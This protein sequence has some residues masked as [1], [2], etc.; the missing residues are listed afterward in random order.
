MIRRTVEVSTPS[1]LHVQHAQLVIE[2]DGERAGQVPIEDLGVLLVDH[3]GAVL[4]EGL[5]AACAENDATVV[6]CDDKHLPSA[7]LLPLAGHSVQAETIRAQTAMSLPLRKRLW[8]QVVQ[9]K[10]K[11]QA[12]VLREQTG[13]AAPL[14]AMIARV[15]S[16]DPDNVEAQAAR[17]YWPRLFGPDFRRNRSA[18][19]ANALLNYGYSVLRA[20]AARAVCAA[21]LHPSVSLHHHNRYDALCLASDLMEPVRP[22]VDRTVH[23]M[24]DEG[25]NAPPL[26]KYAKPPLLSVLSE[27]VLMGKREFPLLVAMQML[28]ASLRRT[29]VNRKGKLEL[30]ALRTDE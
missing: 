9:A 17:A 6:F 28:A 25:G 24:L 4:S 1:Y 7:V 16:G 11:A 2:R 5:L 18:E 14:G 10:I 19:G 15:R 22:I 27:G 21:G 3:S 30:P 23:G 8:Q 13:S 29:A 20:A 26:D 12:A